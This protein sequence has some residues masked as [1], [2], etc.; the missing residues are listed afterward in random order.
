MVHFFSL[1]KDFYYPALAHGFYRK[2][3]RRVH[4][5]VTLSFLLLR[6]KFGNDK[7]IQVRMFGFVV[8]ASSPQVLLRLIKEIFLE[9]V[10]LFHTSNPS[11]RIIDGGAN[12]GISV[13]YF[14]FLYPQARLIAIEPNPVAFQFLEKNIAQNG[15]Q[16]VEAVHACL[17]DNPG[18]ERFYVSAT[19]NIINGSVFPGTGSIFLQEVDA[20][21]L[22]DY[23]AKGEFD[24][25]K[26]DVE[27]AERQVFIDLKQTKSISRSTQYLLEYH[28]APE[29]EDVYFDIVEAFEQNGFG[30]LSIHEGHS[31]TE[32]ENRM[33][34]FKQTKT[35]IYA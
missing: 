31:I 8:S 33:M 2:N 14:K 17:S 6:A 24:L 34:R 22:S 7:D 28:A 11:P 20:V 32:G 23:L 5:L 3:Y 18:R 1:L 21:R 9:Q 27:G 16:D 15:L 26:L 29:L 19:G 4:L 35:L 12:M 10:Y 30:S 25:V 13:L